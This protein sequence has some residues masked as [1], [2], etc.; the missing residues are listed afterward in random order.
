VT[1]KLFQE[2][3]SHEKENRTGNE[4]DGDVKTSNWK[5]D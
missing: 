3:Q 5:C 2:L 4:T 1:E